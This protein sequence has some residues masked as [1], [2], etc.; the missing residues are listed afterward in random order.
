MASAAGRQVP[1][2]RSV[3]VR[4]DEAREGEQA[5][6]ALGDLQGSSPV[7]EDRQRR[8][9]HEGPPGDRVPRGR[10]PDQGDR[11]VPRSGADPPGARSEPAD[12]VH[13]PDQGTRRRRAGAA[14]R[15]Q[16]DAPHGRLG[17]QAEGAR[18][19]GRARRQADRPAAEAAAAGTG[20]PATAAPAAAATAPVRRAGTGQRRRQ[21]EPSQRRPGP[22]E[23]RQRHRA[24]AKAGSAEAGAGREAGSAGQHRLAAS[25]TGGSR[26]AAPAAKPATTGQ[27][28]TA[29]Q[30]R[31]PRPGRPTEPGH[32][33]PAATGE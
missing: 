1:R 10:R 4:A 3:Q 8:L 5:A 27:D 13:G 20:R 22:G 14:A 18:G 26:A 15:R 24:G 25:G 7:A 12:E 2:L 29:G 11:P 23:R 32:Q 6:A 16:V 31:R 19:T 30:R 33:A 21:R 17:P 28:A 9:R